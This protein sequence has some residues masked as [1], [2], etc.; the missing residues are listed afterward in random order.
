[1]H[2]RFP[3]IKKTASRQTLLEIVRI[4][5]EQKLIEL[6]PEDLHRQIKLGE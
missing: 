1:M 6:T 3:G 4:F 5:N 2:K